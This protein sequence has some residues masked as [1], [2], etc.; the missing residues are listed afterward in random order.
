MS[1]YFRRYFQLKST[2]S[3]WKEK[4]FL[5]VGPLNY[6][7]YY[8][9]CN[10]LGC[11]S[12]ETNVQK[13]HDFSS[14]IEVENEYQYI[15]HYRHPFESILELFCAQ[16]Y[17]NSE[18][19]RFM[20]SKIDDWIRFKEK[21]VVGAS[22]LP[23][24]RLLPYP[25]LLASTEHIIW[26]INHI[27]PEHSVDENLL[28]IEFKKN[29][30]VVDTSWNSF[31][32]NYLTELQDS[33]VAEIASVGLNPLDL[34][35]SSKP[36]KEIAQTVLPT[37]YIFY[38]DDKLLNL[39]K[40]VLHSPENISCVDLNDLAIPENLSLDSLDEFDNRAIYSEYLGH[41]AIRPH[42]GM[43]GLFTYSIPLKFNE[44][45]VSQLKTNGHLFKP[46]LDFGLLE[47]AT[48]DQ[49]MLYGVEYSPYFGDDIGNTIISEI[50]E[51]VELHI[52]PIDNPITGP[53]KG[54]VIVRKNLF[55]EYQIWLEKCT[56]YILKNYGF[57]TGVSFKEENNG[58]YWAKEDISYDLKLR[59]GIGQIQ[60][61][62]M[63][64]FFG[65]KFSE[66]NKVDLKYHLNKQ[67]FFTLL[68]IS[69]D[70]P[71][72]SQLLK[73]NLSN[74]YIKECVLFTNH[75]ATQYENDIKVITTNSDNLLL[76]ALTYASTS[77]INQNIVIVTLGVNVAENIYKAHDYLDDNIAVVIQGKQSYDELS[78]Q[79]NSQCQ[80][81]EYEFNGSGG[82]LDL[83]K[84]DALVTRTPIS[85]KL[86]SGLRNGQDIM[87][88]MDGAEYKVYNA[89]LE[90]DI[91]LKS[92]PFERIPQFDRL[93]K[94]PNTDHLRNVTP[95]WVQ[96]EHH[97]TRIPLYTYFTPS[98]Q[99]LFTRWFKPSLKDDFNLIVNQYQQKASSGV[100]EEKGWMNTMRDKN[101]LLLQAVEDNFGGYFV[102]ADVDIQFFGRIRSQLVK[103]LG[104]LDMVFQ[105]DA[106]D[107]FGTDFK[108][109]ACS[110]FFF[111]RANE[112]V[113]KF[114]LD[115]RNIIESDLSIKGDQVVFNKVLGMS[116]YL[117]WAYLSDRFY[118]P[119]PGNAKLGTQWVWDPLVELDIPEGILMHHAN[120]TVGVKNK[121]LQ[122]EH[123]KQKFSGNEYKSW[124]GGEEQTSKKKIE[125]LQKRLTSAEHKIELCN[126]IQH[127]SLA[128][129]EALRQTN[130][131]MNLQLEEYKQFKDTVE[132]SKVWKAVQFLLKPINILRR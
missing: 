68:V 67:R 123:V 94:V 39:S 125:T 38:H 107:E 28:S 34:G 18:W 58:K 104:N 29:K 60:E 69:N 129:I 57:Q 111:C 36:S 40:P 51:D 71:P 127:K 76:E 120:W 26:V 102:F 81:S 82:F 105:R 96:K 98:H 122:L 48:F 80:F 97:P 64:Y 46:Y 83:S 21:W 61:R 77:A 84:I 106:N 32:I 124:V 7:E 90:C 74:T 33:I 95:Y 50:D 3:I 53:F 92:G 17:P 4:G 44:Q 2:N 66:R 27:A 101:D 5:S 132:K 22:I 86:L 59:R 70:H 41:L 30:K 75:S 79:L 13:N 115:V 35:S 118:S 62:L 99:S 114:F 10:T 117:K 93:K 25:E 43:V 112:R 72:G 14:N 131:S 24:V 91:I 49:D 56:Q 12:V 78:G 87:Q 88:S 126:Q 23:N 109:V 121:I 11:S 103:E 31:D 100:F 73:E 6:C 130:L 128:E 20:Q 9:H 113:R 119:G 42:S 85:P 1:G 8:S 108:G 45:Y 54:T 52:P 19:K 15:V 116:H 37:H 16:K 47:N 89:S 63:A 110:G 65:R 55:E